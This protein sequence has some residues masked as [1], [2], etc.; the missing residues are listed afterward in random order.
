M[1][2]VDVKEI[3]QENDVIGS[4]VFFYFVLSKLSLLTAPKGKLVARAIKNAS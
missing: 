4:F 1:A 3:L 2:N